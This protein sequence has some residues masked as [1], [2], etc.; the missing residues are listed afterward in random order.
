VEEEEDVYDEGKPNDE[1]EK[2]KKIKRGD[3]E[4]KIERKR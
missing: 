4:C 1:K 3:W 2:E